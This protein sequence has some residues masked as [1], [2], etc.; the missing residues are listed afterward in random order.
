MFDFILGQKVIEKSAKALLIVL[1]LEG[2]NLVVEPTTDLDI[3]T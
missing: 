3:G 2:L 1:V